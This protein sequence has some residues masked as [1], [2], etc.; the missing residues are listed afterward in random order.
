MTIILNAEEVEVPAGT[1]SYED[2]VK[3]INGTGY[4]SV[5]YKGKSR[6]DLH[7]SGTLTPGKSVALEEGMII[8]AVVTG[9][10]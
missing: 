1:I 9:N 3:V 4:E 5:V 10:A 6:G 7:R 8:S 2:V